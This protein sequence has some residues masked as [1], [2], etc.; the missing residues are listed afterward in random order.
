MSTCHFSRVGRSGPEKM[1]R[2]SFDD[3]PC[4]CR[5]HDAPQKQT[6]SAQQHIMPKKSAAQIRRMQKRA[7]ARG[8]NY[9]YEAPEAAQ[10]RV[11]AD[12]DN[13]CNSDAAGPNESSSPQKNNIVRAKAAK[14]LKKTLEDIARN[15]D[16]K[17]KER[18][19]AKRR[20]EAIATEE[21]GGCDADSLLEWYENEGSAIKI[22][23]E[24]IDFSSSKG[25]A[26]KMQKKNTPYILFIGQLAFSTSAEGLFKHIQD[27]IGRDE[28]TGKEIITPE[29]LK[30][31]LL[32]D[33][34]KKNRSRGMAFV[35][36]NDPELSY[37][38]LKLHHTNLDGRRIN[39]ERSAGGGKK[40]KARKE[41]IISYRKEQ[42][43][44]MNETVNRIIANH[45]NQGDLEDGELDDGVISLM[46]RHAA[47]TVEISLAEYIEERGKDMDNPSAYLTSII[48]RVAVEG[49]DCKNKPI[50][51]K[52][53][54]TFGKEGRSKRGNGSGSR[55][56][57]HMVG[58]GVG[59]IQESGS[60]LSMSSSFAKAGV[61]MSISD[62]RSSGDKSML[63]I[64]PSMGRGRGRGAYMGR[65]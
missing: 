6:Q 2:H 12:I 25:P 21:A 18:R 24:S 19:S 42:E 40:S 48:S 55:S 49:A 27:Q 32:T 23:D 28:R 43:E 52:Q 9:R 61:D 11:A 35:E 31:R 44:Y 63:T 10:N 1:I 13:T 45:R 65:H 56:Q 53:K 41:K 62:K 51:T 57:K 4:P 7:E 60:P 39:V 3:A 5:G 14:K 8:D 38:L 22:L 17:A 54:D 29:T 26:A 47:A 20:A 36:T 33:E 50:Y 58:G 59:M 37:Q 15:A 34:K 64:F 16:L 30:V 46:R